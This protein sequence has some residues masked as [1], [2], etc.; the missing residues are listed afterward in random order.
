VTSTVVSWDFFDEVPE[1][2]WEE[3]PGVR[4]PGRLVLND[5]GFRRVADDLSL[6]PINAVPPTK[7]RWWIVPI[8]LIA[9]MS[10][11]WYLRR[12]RGDSV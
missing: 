9:V 4:D 11:S 10:V 2:L 12:H 3:P 5:N 6:V 8:T 7:T 1:T